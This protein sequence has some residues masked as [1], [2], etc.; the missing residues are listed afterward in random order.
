MRAHG[1]P[2]GGRSP[3]E[4][5]ILELEQRIF[6]RP[7]CE[8]APPEGASA[9]VEADLAELQRLRASVGAAE[10]TDHG[11]ERAHPDHPRVVDET[12]DAAEVSAGRAPE[13]GIPDRRETAV[14]RGPLRLLFGAGAASIAAGVAAGILFGPPVPAALAMLDSPVTP[15]EHVR[16]EVLRDAGLPL[17]A[18]G[19]SVAD[20][21]T[22]A[23]VGFRAPQGTADE[24]R[25]D[26]ATLVG[27]ELSP[28]GGAIYLLPDPTTL[29]RA[30]IRRAE[31]CAWVVERSFAIEGRCT[32]LD[33]FARDGLAFETERFG[34]RYA[35]EWSPTGEAELRALPVEIVEP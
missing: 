10:H 33:D 27:T 25:A 6:G 7:D 21:A 4:A 28:F 16:S 23:L 13:P 26:D 20:S 18:D 32:P 12:S 9:D 22:A 2:T 5:R 34:V 29:D 11:D 19:R 14:P 3:R 1:S 17:L 15:L 30:G 35:V 31:V 24:L 8:G